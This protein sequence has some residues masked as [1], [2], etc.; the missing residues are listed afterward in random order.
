M[1]ECKNIYY[2]VDKFILEDFS[3]KVEN[4]QYVGLLG[5][6]GSGKSVILEI[7]AGLRHQDSGQIFLGKDDL[8]DVSALPPQKRNC[9]YL[10]QDYALF[11]H[12]NVF[13]NISYPLRYVKTPLE[14][15]SE[16]DKKELVYN[17]SKSFNI[18][19]LLHR[20]PENLSGGEKQRVALARTLI[21]K[22]DV[23][24]LDEPLSA[25][26]A[27][28]RKASLELFSS[29]AHDGLSI[30]HVTHDIEEINSVSDYIIQ[31]TDR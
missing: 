17:I 21:T 10:F 12:K 26:D 27:P 25:L 5:P 19:D 15:L 30:V 2:H 16:S 29:L 31:M 4:S 8:I 18:T 14:P 3:M 23:L 20:M 9:G 1:L 6:S 11:P 22:P 28:L 13:E 24:L 7:I